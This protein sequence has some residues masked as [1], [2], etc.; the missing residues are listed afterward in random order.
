MLGKDCAPTDHIHCVILSGVCGTRVPD[1]A[2]NIIPIV[3]R[4]TMV[5]LS[6]KRLRY[7]TP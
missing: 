6:K 2:L 4:S 7:R 3:G 1:E 5:E